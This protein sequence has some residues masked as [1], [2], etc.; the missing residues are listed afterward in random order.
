VRILQIK[1]LSIPVIKFFFL[2]GPA[3]TK[4]SSKDFADVVCS[5]MRQRAPK[6]PS[7]LTVDQINESLDKLSKLESGK[8]RNMT[9]I[10]QPLIRQLPAVE[11]KW[12]VRIILRNVR[13]GAGQKPLLKAY[14]PDAQELYNVC[15]DLEK[16]CVTLFDLS[17]RSFALSISLFKPF[18]PML[19]DQSNLNQIVSKMGNKMFFV[20]TKLDG[21][22][23]Q[24]HID[25]DRYIFF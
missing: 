18:S 1:D 5:I 25:G 22:R 12:L 11:Q 23:T 19:A 7:E 17:N 10:L 2:R 8:N 15:Y 14:H 24:I 6:P 3:T 13:C 9:S 20:E 16:V 21:E 4:T